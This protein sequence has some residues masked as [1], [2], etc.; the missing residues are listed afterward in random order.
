MGEGVMPSEKARERTRKRI[1]IGDFG[2]PED[3]AYGILYL[4]S[5][6]SRFVTGTELVIDGGMNAI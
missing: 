6:E 3:I 5:D 4:V 1:P 2:A